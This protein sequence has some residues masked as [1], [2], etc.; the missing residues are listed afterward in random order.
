VLQIVA[1]FG[2]MCIISVGIR[3][4]G[5]GRWWRF[6]AYRGEGAVRKFRWSHNHVTYSLRGSVPQQR[7][8]LTRYSRLSQVDTDAP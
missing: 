6:G 8:A 3:K 5:Q 1:L 2:G 7:S 4:C